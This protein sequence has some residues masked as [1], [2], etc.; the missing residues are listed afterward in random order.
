MSRHPSYAGSDPLATIKSRH[1]IMFP[2]ALDQRAALP[3]SGPS[4]S[5]PR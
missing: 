4:I 2:G 5:A 3:A 1:A